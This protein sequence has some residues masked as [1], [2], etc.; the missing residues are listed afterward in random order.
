MDVVPVK[1]Q[2]AVMSRHKAFQNLN[3]RDPTYRE[4]SWNILQRLVRGVGTPLPPIPRNWIFL[5]DLADELNIPEPALVNLLVSK[6]I[7]PSHACFIDFNGIRGLLG[8]CSPS[9]AATLRN[10]G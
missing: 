8:F 7:S 2:R 10:K 6:Q 4:Q 1:L 5:G 9:L 3:P